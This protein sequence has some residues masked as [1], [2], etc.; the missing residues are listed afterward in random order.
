MLSVCAYKSE[1]E[2]KQLSYNVVNIFPHDPSAFTQGLVWD[3]GTVYEGTGIYGAS[4]LRLVNYK[5]GKIEK[6][7]NYP[8][9]I[10]AEG[11]TVFQ[12]KIYQL[13]WQ[14]NMVFVYDKYDFSLLRTHNYHREGWGL[15]HDD[16]HLIASDGSAMLYFLDPETLIEKKQITVRDNQGPVINLNELEYIKGKVFAN[17]LGSDRIA[18]INP[19]SGIVESWIDLS[20]LRKL[21]TEQHDARDLNGIM[22]D[23]ENDRLFVTGKLWPKLFEISLNH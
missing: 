9:D 12:D 6:S 13:T 4:S 20:G 15:T 18:V 22:Y 8:L 14:N 1:T 7:I 16:H 19:E 17:I 2:P 3:D 21:M 11:V 23:A 5:T 10:F